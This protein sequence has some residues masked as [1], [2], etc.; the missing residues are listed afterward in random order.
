MISDMYGK[1]RPLVSIKVGNNHPMDALLQ[2][3]PSRPH[4]MMRVMMILLTVLIL[5]L[6]ASMME[7]MVTG[8]DD[9]EV[10]GWMAL[11]KHSECIDQRS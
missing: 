9:G 2:L 6:R 10:G 3:P 4:K 7:A 11:A 5:S 1:V 8:E